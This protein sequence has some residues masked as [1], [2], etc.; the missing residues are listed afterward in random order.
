[1]PRKEPGEPYYRLDSRF[2]AGFDDNLSFV[3]RW[4]S[5][6]PLLALR[7]KQSTAAGNWSDSR[8]E[9]NAA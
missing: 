4:Q 1:M 8:T 7:G 9:A 2:D 5:R 3:L 6:E